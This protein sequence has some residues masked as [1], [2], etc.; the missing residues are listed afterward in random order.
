MKAFV[1]AIFNMPYEP[2][3]LFR[4]YSFKLDWDAIP[5]LKFM[6]AEELVLLIV[7]AT[8]LLSSN[9]KLSGVLSSRWNMVCD[10][11]IS[12]MF[13]AVKGAG[14]KGESLEALLN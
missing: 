6:A 3:D 8:D 10:A 13:P 11:V 1:S 9:P 2:L 4:H 14:S 12:S 5:V 7:M